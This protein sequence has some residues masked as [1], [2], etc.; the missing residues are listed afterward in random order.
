MRLAGKICYECKISPPAPYTRGEQLCDRCA[1]QQKPRR[2]VYMTF[3]LSHGWYCQFLEAD[4][5]AQQRVSGRF[6]R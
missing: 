4:L 5:I 2:R 3:F 6:S 1:E